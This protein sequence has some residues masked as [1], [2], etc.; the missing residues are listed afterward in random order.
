MSTRLHIYEGLFKDKEYIY[1]VMVISELWYYI[2]IFYI[3][4]KS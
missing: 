3:P 4:K 1:N 2:K